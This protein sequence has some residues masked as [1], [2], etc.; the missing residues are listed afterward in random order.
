MEIRNNQE[1]HI[2]EGIRGTV[3]LWYKLFEINGYTIWYHDHKE[4]EKRIYQITEGK[5]PLT[6]IGYNKLYPLLRQKDL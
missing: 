6:N 3:N 1:T 2:T 4:T 5:E